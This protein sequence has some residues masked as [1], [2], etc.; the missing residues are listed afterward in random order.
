MNKVVNFIDQAKEFLFIEDYQGLDKALGDDFNKLIDQYFAKKDERIFK[1]SAEEL[2]D[3][4]DREAYGFSDLG[5]DNVIEDLSLSMSNPLIK[6][7]RNKP[8]QIR[9]MTLEDNETGYMYLLIDPEESIYQGI[10]QYLKMGS[11][12]QFAFSYNNKDYLLVMMKVK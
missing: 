9:W 1:K 5:L 11:S 12:Y 3:Y 7:Y 6:K 10:E 2:L 8:F 4:F